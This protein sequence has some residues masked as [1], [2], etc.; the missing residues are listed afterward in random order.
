MGKLTSLKKVLAYYL[1]V[2]KSNFVDREIGG[3]TM[4]SVKGSI[5][6][7]LDKDDAWFFELAKHHECF[8]DVGANIGYTSLLAAALPN[9][10]ELF[11][12]DANREALAI[13][14]QNLI[15]N[16]FGHKCHFVT[17]FLGDEPAEGIQFYTVG[18]GSAGSK[19][20]GHAHTAS[21]VNSYYYVTQTTIDLLIEERG[22]PV[23]FIKIDVEGAEAAVLAGATTT[24][25]KYAPKIIVEMH[26]PPELPMVENARLI[27][28]WCRA[29]QYVAY[30]LKDKVELCTP[31]QI[32]HRGR[33][34]VLLLRS[35][36]PFPDYLKDIQEGGKLL[37]L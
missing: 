30:Y 37:P 5:P 23:D 34:H 14:A 15:I 2:K 3:K 22:F 20:K 11:L 18:S 21:L 29:N 19:F 24:V 35:E 6:D 28:E 27:I 12:I 4:K 17:T 16:G 8:L 13:A 33:C 9:N 7:K 26:S 10:K 31:D 32:S 36:T 1:N 25:K